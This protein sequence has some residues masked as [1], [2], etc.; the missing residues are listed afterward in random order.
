ML[1]MD[2]IRI[3]V[4]GEGT[5]GVGITLLLAAENYEVVLVGRSRSSS[6][7]TPQKGLQ[8]VRSILDK[9]VQKGK[10]TVE[11]MDQQ[12]DHISNP[13][14]LSGLH[15]VDFL[16]EAVF[17]DLE[18]KRALYAELNA[19]CPSNT[20]FASNTSSIPINS[21]AGSTKRPD[22]FIGMHFMNPP[23]IMKLVEIVSGAQTSEQTRRRAIDLA[24][25]V[26]KT[27]I[28]VKDSPGFIANRI[29]MP[30][31]N[32]A[33]YCLQEGEGTVESI[34]AIAKLGLNHPMGP[35]ELA[36]FIGLDVCL[37]IMRVM[38]V[39]FHDEKYA[40]CPLLVQM[41]QR[42]ELGRKSGKGFYDHSGR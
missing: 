1:K 15:G 24:L 13:G 42:G 12:L 25:S 28:E 16:I 33:I 10:M 11:T 22:R 21:L 8:K 5:M 19:V 27:C 17:E 36:D 29:L 34:D 32:E 41:V 30:L 39:N 18:V 35:L 4:V 7:T 23:Q 26:G 6:P 2:K 37:Q 9:K 38:H 40:P 20:I 3:G 14:E 31:I